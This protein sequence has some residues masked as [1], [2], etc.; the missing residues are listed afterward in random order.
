MLGLFISV[1]S[2]QFLRSVSIKNCSVRYLSIKLLR[3]FEAAQGIGISS[4][5]VESKH[6]CRRCRP[7]NKAFAESST[8]LFDTLISS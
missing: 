8:R 2:Q 1:V 6:C 7:C 4:S 3:K 5:R